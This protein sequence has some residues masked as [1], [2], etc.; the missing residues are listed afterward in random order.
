[1]L[2]SLGTARSCTSQ[3]SVCGE[4]AKTKEQQ[5][6]HQDPT[7]NKTKNTRGGIGKSQDP[8]R[9]L[10]AL[11]THK[12]RITLVRNVEMEVGL[13][14]PNRRYHGRRR[15]QNLE[16]RLGWMGRCDPAGVYGTSDRRNSLVIMDPR[17]LV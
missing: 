11:A 13:G 3:G 4:F 1:M 15:G 6:K 9:R 5:Q 12:N 2:A 7:T 17:C 10:T 8:R 14:R 16:K